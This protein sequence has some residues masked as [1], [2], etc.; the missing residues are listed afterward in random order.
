MKLKKILRWFVIIAIFPIVIGLIVNFTT[1]FTTKDNFNITFKLEGWIT[2]GSIQF[3]DLPNL[4]LTL[5]DQQVENIL[6]VTWSIKNT[7][8]KGIESFESGPW[9]EIPTYLNLVSANISQKSTLLNISNVLSCHENR[10]IVDSL[11]LFNTNDYFVIDIYLRDIKNQN[12]T[13]HY[14]ENWKLIGKSLDLSISRDSN[15][16]EDKKSEFYIPYN[17]IITLIITLSILGSLFFLFLEQRKTIKEFRA[18]EL[19]RA[20]KELDKWEIIYRDIKKNKELN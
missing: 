1:W 11:G 5:E 3:G 16:V 6:K 14:F 10:V 9:I 20:N 13:R 4:K 7:G 15:I 8:N 12:I 2:V 18:S 19:L 17:I